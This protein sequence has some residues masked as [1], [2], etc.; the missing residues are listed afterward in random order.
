M[1]HRIRGLVLPVVFAFAFIFCSLSVFV[2]PAFWWP[3]GM[4]AALTL[5]G[6]IDLLQ[7]A[8]ALLRNYPILGHLRFLLED[9]GPEM[10][11]YFVESNTS[12]ASF[13]RDQRS[14]IYQRSKGVKDKKPFGTELNVY[15]D[16]YAWL[17]HSLLPAE[18]VPDAARALRVEVGGPGCDQPYSASVFNISA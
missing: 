2:H 7:P 10:R 14:L 9:F 8:H 18:V 17:E 5:I 15:A 3:S 13:N 16:G 6:I 12:G 1:I 11:Q 4:F